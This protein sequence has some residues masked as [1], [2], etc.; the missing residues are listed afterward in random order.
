M[1]QLSKYILC[2]GYH[3]HYDF[4]SCNILFLF[5]LR[6]IPTFFGIRTVLKSRTCFKMRMN[7][8]THSSGWTNGQNLFSTPPHLQLNAFVCI[9]TEL[10][11]VNAIC[12]THSSFRESLSIIQRHGKKQQQ[13]NRMCGHLAL[14]Q[15]YCCCSIYESLT[16]H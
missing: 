13:C 1:R 10:L 9:N 14:G 5:V 6:H 15:S 11:N 3:G 2:T 8:F 4:D 12:S 7:V 16:S